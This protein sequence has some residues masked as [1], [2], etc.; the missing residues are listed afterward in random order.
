MHFD[1]GHRHVWQ[2]QLKRLPVRAIVERNEH[3]K[4]RS[5]VKQSFA[6]RIFADDAR[7]PI[8]WDAVV[9]I[10]QSRP[11]LT[12][13]VGAINVWLIIAEEPTVHGVVGRSFPMRRRLNVLHASSSGKI[14]WRHVGPGL[15]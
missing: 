12:V 5:G 13:I 1:V 3:S 10:S 6:V 14:L 9:S 7:G 4:F 11:G 2:I 15:S 8:R